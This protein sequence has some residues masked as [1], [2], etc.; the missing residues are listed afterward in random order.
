MDLEQN[1]LITI[2]GPQYQEFQM[3]PQIF[4]KDPLKIIDPLDPINPKDLKSVVPL[5]G[6]LIQGGLTPHMGDHMVGLNP[7][8]EVMGDHITIQDRFR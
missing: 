6:I 1:H 2:K 7:L 4:N 5:W 8:K 3:D